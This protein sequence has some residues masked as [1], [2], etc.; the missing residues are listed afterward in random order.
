MTMNLSPLLF[1]VSLPDLGEGQDRGYVMCSWE[2]LRHS[3][4]QNYNS[5]EQEK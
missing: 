2:G 1:R 4:G 3:R 5:K